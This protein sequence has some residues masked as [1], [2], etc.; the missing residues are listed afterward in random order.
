MGGDLAIADGCEFAAQELDWGAVLCRRPF[1]VD[2]SDPRTS[3]QGGYEIVE[4]GIGL[5]DLVIHV[6]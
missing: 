1:E 6:H 2:N 3:L 4:E 5:S